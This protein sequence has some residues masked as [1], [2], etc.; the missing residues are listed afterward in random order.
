M[1][2]VDRML[3]CLR[4]PYIAPITEAT[5]SLQST[6]FKVG[7]CILHSIKSLGLVWRWNLSESSTLH[8]CFE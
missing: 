1:K 4:L 5:P 6:T 8:V 2:V 7:H 3:A